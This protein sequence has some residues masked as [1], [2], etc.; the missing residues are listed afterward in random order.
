VSLAAGTLNRRIRINRREAGTGPGGEPIDNWLP[1]FRRLRARP[2]TQKGMATIA[3]LQGGEVAASVNS[4]SWEI[5]YRPTGIDVGMQLVYQGIAFD[6][7]SLKHDFERH[8]WTNIICQQGG[9]AG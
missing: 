8:Q 3:G 7:I 6:I 5:R 1:V 4:Y 2:M 9:N